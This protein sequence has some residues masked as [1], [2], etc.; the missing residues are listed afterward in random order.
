ME[1]CTL[2]GRS[3][4]LESSTRLDTRLS[5]RSFAFRWSLRLSACLALAAVL[6]G[7]APAF[8]ATAAQA[9]AAQARAAQQAAKQA[10]QAK[11]AKAA[12]TQAAPPGGP[13]RP[14]PSSAP[15]LRSGTATAPA[16]VSPGGSELPTPTTQYNLTFNIGQP[17]RSGCLVCHS[18]KNLQKL[19]AGREKSFYISEAV[20][21]QSAHRNVPCTGCH[22]DFNFQSPHGKASIGFRDVAGLS[23]RNCHARDYGL[24]QA[25]VH[26]SRLRGNTKSPTC[27]DCH[28]A[29]DIGYIT[30]SPMAAA[31]LHKR[32]FLVCGRCHQRYWDNYSDYYHGIAYKNGAQDA[33]AC[34][35]CHRSHDIYN[36]KNPLA[37]TNPA[38]L[39]M[40][41][42]A[43][44]GG[45]QRGFLTYTPLIHTSGSVRQA[46]PVLGYY[47]AIRVW[48]A[49]TLQSI[50]GGIRSIF[51]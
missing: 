7:P 44:H 14:P 38:N 2:E 31:S 11:Q 18:D 41:C 33:P 45:T 28:G 9:K 37:S 49:S 12:Q 35:Q 23:C 16:Y 34:W 36:S 8:A 27:S 39:A 1:G 6:T 50:F 32:G 42:G 47:E 46:I 10:K 5:H 24:Y 30:K 51:G 40:T 3:E 25:G 48:I 22:L 29:H 4:T 43:C 15:G 17:G 19:T 26:G 20:I 13:G 21:D